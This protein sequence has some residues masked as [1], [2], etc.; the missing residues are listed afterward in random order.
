MLFYHPMA[1]Y[2]DEKDGNAKKLFTYDPVCSLEECKTVFRVWEDNYGYQQIV[3]FAQVYDGGKKV[4]VHEFTHSGN[5][6]EQYKMAK[7]WWDV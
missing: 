3:Q 6:E 4:G 5:P 1:V 2:V 7:D